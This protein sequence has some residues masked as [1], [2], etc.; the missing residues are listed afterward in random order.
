[1][2]FFNPSRTGIS[3]KHS[4]NRKNSIFDHFAVWIFIFIMSS[5]KVIASPELKFPEDSCIIYCHYQESNNIYQTASIV[6]LGPYS[7]ES[8][9]RYCVARVQS[10]P[11]DNAIDTALELFL[12]CIED[13]YASQR[14]LY[15]FPKLPRQQTSKHK[16]TQPPRTT[17]VYL[18]VNCK[19]TILKNLNTTQTAQY[20]EKLKT[21]NMIVS[22]LSNDS[23][24][25]K[26]DQY[27]NFDLRF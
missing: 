17:R 1:M 21:H 24:L 13:D 2:L 15:L 8:K 27:P 23:K 5:S 7:A 11:N 26:Q 3:Y 18:L 4:R 20:V 16:T 19:P 14:P 10:A 22:I 9:T 12:Q 25:P 6:I